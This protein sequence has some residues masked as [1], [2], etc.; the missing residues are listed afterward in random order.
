MKAAGTGNHQL[1]RAWI[2]VPKVDVAGSVRV[3][4]GYRSK[5]LWRCFDADCLACIVTTALLALLQAASGSLLQNKPLSPC[6]SLTLS[7]TQTRFTNRL[8]SQQRV[9]QLVVIRARLRESWPPIERCWVVASRHKLQVRVV[10]RRHPA[11]G[12]LSK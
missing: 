12:Q 4:P 7:T 8:K 3:G 11:P 2:R 9:S 1:G 6:V 10:E 5:F